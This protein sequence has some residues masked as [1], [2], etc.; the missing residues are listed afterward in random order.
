MPAGAH[1][2]QVGAIQC[3]VLSDGY[4]AYPT[5]W[6]FPNADAAQLS[7]SLDRRG[8]PREQVLSPYTCLL[9][10]TGRHVVLIDAGGGSGS[11]T[12]AIR[13]RL[14]MEGIRPRDVDTV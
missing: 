9:V 7:E 6:F 5:P 3:T 14:E 12:G 10:E 13:A 11:T 2:F 4:F 8:M 1:R